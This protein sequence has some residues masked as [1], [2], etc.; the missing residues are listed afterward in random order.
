M[1]GDAQIQKPK[2]F[3]FTHGNSEI[4]PVTHHSSVSCPELLKS[5][6]SPSVAFSVVLGRSRAQPHPNLLVL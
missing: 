6:I 4:S 5:P 2:T 3:S 1:R